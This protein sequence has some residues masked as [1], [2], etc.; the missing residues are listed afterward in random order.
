MLSINEAGLI[1]DI[2]E[3]KNE[4][5]LLSFK[6]TDP[7]R[8]YQDSVDAA[9]KLYEARDHFQKQVRVLRHFRRNYQNN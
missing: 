1:P 7:L 5:V 6:V 4:Y 3:T 8:D 9:Q 2:P